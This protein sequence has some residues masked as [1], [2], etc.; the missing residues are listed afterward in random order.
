VLVYRIE[1]FDKRGAYSSGAAFGMGWSKNHPSPHEDLS[2]KEWWDSRGNHNWYFG[3]HSM[4][5]LIQW[6]PKDCWDVFLKHNAARPE[7][8]KKVGIS[9]YDCDE[10]DVRIGEKQTVFILDKAERVKIL[11]FEDELVA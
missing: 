7:P 11:A 8:E 1:T 5:Q 10:E 2:L 6:F 4:E 3:F 9:I